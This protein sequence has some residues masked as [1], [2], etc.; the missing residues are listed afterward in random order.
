MKTARSPAVAGCLRSPR[1]ALAGHGWHSAYSAYS[2][3]TCYGSRP[4]TAVRHERPR[5]VDKQLSA[6][7]GGLIVRQ[8]DEFGGVLLEVADNRQHG[9]QRLREWAAM[10]R[11]MGLERQYGVYLRCERWGWSIKL[12]RQDN[13]P[14]P[15]SVKLRLSIC[16]YPAQR[17]T[18]E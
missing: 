17:G 18:E 11:N 6:P 4:L 12:A 5:T 1:C 3:F 7:Y 10:L 8:P 9:K 14:M 15:Q 16:S 13:Q 2:A